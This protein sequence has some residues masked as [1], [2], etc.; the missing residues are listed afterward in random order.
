[1]KKQNITEAYKK[2][3]KK[4]DWKFIF[5]RCREYKVRIRKDDELA[6]LCYKYLTKKQRMKPYKI[7]KDKNGIPGFASPDVILEDKACNLIVAKY[8][9]KNHP[10]TVSGETI[11]KVE[12]HI[13]ET[14]KEYLNPAGQNNNIKT[15][16]RKIKSTK[17]KR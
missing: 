11:R 13:K 10:E 7:P 5:D 16:K 6:V 12:K 2:I 9:N 15:L 14:L 3:L 8:I 17:E 4:V 1:M